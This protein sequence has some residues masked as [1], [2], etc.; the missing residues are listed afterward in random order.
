MVLGIASGHRGSKS[1][2]TIVH[3][4]L[5][6]SHTADGGDIPDSRRNHN[7]CVARP[8]ARR[9]PL[10]NK[11]LGVTRPRDTGQQLLYVVSRQCLLIITHRLSAADLIGSKEGQQYDDSVHW[12]E[13]Q[14]K[15]S[16]NRLT[17]AV[18]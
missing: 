2:C 13:H 15:E 6:D 9:V 12:S 18:E 5:A 10:A 17:F 7:Q 16:W 1:T 8:I 3:K 14:G 11:Q 4:M